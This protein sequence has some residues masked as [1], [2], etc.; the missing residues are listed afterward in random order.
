MR[1]ESRSATQQSSHS[2]YNS[3][4]LSRHHSP[5]QLK[6]RPHYL[7]R[8]A[9]F[10]TMSNYSRSFTVPRKPLLAPTPVAAHKRHAKFMICRGVEPPHLL[11]R[12]PST[13]SLESL[14][15]IESEMREFSLGDLSRSVPDLASTLR[16]PLVLS[17]KEVTGH[18]DA[19]EGHPIE[20]RQ[21]DYAINI[22]QPTDEE[23]MTFPLSSTS[24]YRTSSTGSSASRLPTK[25][26]RYYSQA[27]CSED[28]E[29]LAAGEKNHNHKQWIPADLLDY[30]N[31]RVELVPFC[32]NRVGILTAIAE[33]R[34]CSEQ[35][36]LQIANTEQYIQDLFHGKLG[37]VMVDKKVRHLS[38]LPRMKLKPE[39]VGKITYIQRQTNPRASSGPPASRSMV[40]LHQPRASIQVPQPRPSGQ[41]ELPVTSRRTEERP[42]ISRR[43]RVRPASNGGDYFAVDRHGRKL[44]S[45]SG[46]SSQA[47]SPL[48]YE[49]KAEV[50]FDTF[51]APHKSG[52]GLAL[53]Q[54]GEDTAL[55]TSA[56]RRLNKMPSMPAMRKQKFTFRLRGPQDE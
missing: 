30:Q 43:P 40:D 48:A 33:E 27:L 26:P 20:F 54:E 41:A 55:Q 53:V 44:S 56:R 21:T 3:T 34:R 19:N 25:K 14:Q 42:S 22:R 15:S 51:L 50:T 16:E 23:P 4:A 49:Y 5:S 8:T 9:A 36:L 38:E 17:N 47:S 37:Q 18:V 6:A 7:F 10:D 46:K 13:S 39:Q 12:R 24:G 28:K 45:Q 35:F 31:A 32:E 1:E 29:A 52:K 2:H 11:S